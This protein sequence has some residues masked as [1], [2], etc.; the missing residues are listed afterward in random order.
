MAVKPDKQ[1]F[2]A[3]EREY[4]PLPGSAGKAARAER[5]RLAQSAK[6]IRQLVFLPAS[7]EKPKSVRNLNNNA[8]VMG[9]ERRS[10]PPQ[11][12]R[13]AADCGEYRQAA[14]DSEVDRQ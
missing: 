3:V 5:Y 13:G 1:D 6:I 4:G 8:E 9:D 7:R 14:G 2:A 12:T 11:Q 10:A